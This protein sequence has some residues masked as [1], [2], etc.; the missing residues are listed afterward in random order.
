[1][2]TAGQS[3]GAL[4][5]GSPKGRVLLV[6]DEEQLLKAVTRAL[7]KN[8][9]QVVSAPD[10]LEATQ[11]LDQDSFDLVMSD[12]AMPG[13]GGIEL[14]HRVR[15]RDL[16]V[17]VI[18]M[19]GSPTVDTA[20]KAI[21]LGVLDYLVKPFA[22]PDVVAAVDRAVQMSRLA[23]I[24]R[25]AFEY[26][27]RSGDWVGDR[28]G[29]EVNFAAAMETMWMAYQPIVCWSKREVFAYEALVRPV[30]PALPHPGAL[31]GAAERLG[32]LH[33]L[34]RRLREMVAEGVAPATEI[35]HIFV[36]IHGYD[37]EDEALLS[38]SAALSRIASRV[39]LEITERASVNEIKDLSV[40]IQR[41]RDLGFRIAVD[42]LGAGYAGLTSFAQ[43]RPDIVKIDM[44]L[45]R[46]VDREPTKERLVR[47]LTDL[48]RE[49]KI[50]AVCEGVE[51][52]AELET[53][54]RIGCDFFQGYHFARPGRPFPTVTF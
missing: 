33:L 36:N 16:D 52:P 18:L 22:M 53:L 28:A 45:V 34:G 10:G 9:Y 54:V 29:L 3:V 19:T 49:M 24:K 13:M 41:L 40:R 8:G 44:S 17:P 20:T 48:C 15:Q 47:S 42:D 7:V 35:G 27:N 39:V 38:P 6:D 32:H 26:L 12:I 1:V 23:R 4:Q 43:L 50:L 25:E 37:L 21:Q 51:T 11:R 31:I 2:I 5:N 14:L 30:H 46:D